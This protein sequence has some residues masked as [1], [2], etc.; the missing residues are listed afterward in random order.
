MNYEG[1]I[2]STLISIPEQLLEI[3]GVVY[4]HH[5]ASDG[6]DIY[7]T[8]YGMPHSSLFE[9]ENWYEK[10]WFET[11]RERLEGSSAVYKVTTRE[12]DG[13]SLELVVKNSR[14]GED[15]PLDTRTL[16]EFINTEF[17]SP[18]EEFSMVFEL[19]NSSYGPAGI[20]IKTQYPMAIY[21]PPET[22]QLWQS[23]RSA[24]KVSRIKDRHP[25]IDI[26]ILKQYKLIYEWIKGKNIVEAFSELGIGGAELEINLAPITK[27]VIADLD[28][29][30]Y[31]VAD[32]KP[33]HIIID[34]YNIKKL[35]EL[36]DNRE[37]SSRGKKFAYIL[38]LVERGEYSIVDYELLIRTPANDEFVKNIRRHS[39]LDDQRDR[40]IAAPLPIYLE[41]MMIFNVPYIYGH[42][43][44]TGGLLW[45]VGRNPNLYDYFLPE[46]WRTTH[47]WKLSEKNDVY[48]TITKDNIHI[49][50]KASRVGEKPSSY[51]KSEYGYNSPFE[52]F[53]IADY[54]NK[55]G[56][57]T[58]Y[59][60][61][62]Y[63]TGSAKQESS[64]DM[65]R[66]ET[67]DKLRCPD[68]L[69]VLSAQHNYIT[70]RGYYNGPDRW[71][72]EQKGQLYRPVDLIKS[73]H[74]GVFTEPEI[75]AHI[76]RVVSRLKNI[77]YNGN[78][79]QPDDI[80][81]TYDTKGEIVKDSEG[82]PELRITNLDF[83]RKI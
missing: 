47:N 25:G 13:I 23:G 54:L 66:Y 37:Y 82:Y 31:A 45:V 49:V 36:G 33:S 11:H 20:N 26:D 62:I 63:M 29:K 3:I 72:A 60:R 83:I 50:W 70:I 22:M 21:V 39:Y 69:P 15:V 42:V 59:M 8:Q 5:K 64:E 56:V 46:R 80:I 71:V 58:V 73:L 34:E 9:I 61:A 44:S 75:N 78:L 41:E 76:S 27:R 38:D 65:S 40:F 18:W 32:M 16:M 51:P 52:E 2:S 4:S 1:E 77:G 81:I 79:L 57:N 10:Q 28:K 43:E 74:N 7:L 53:S 6:G 17:N 30:G 67:H 19:R 48:Y 24:Y 35:N 55:N 68:G 14:F 12:I